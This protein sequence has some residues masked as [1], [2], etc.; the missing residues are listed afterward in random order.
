MIILVLLSVN[1][2]TELVDEK[3]RELAVA[4]VGVPAEVTV[5]ELGSES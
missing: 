2:D 1:R 4:S 5:D 3:E